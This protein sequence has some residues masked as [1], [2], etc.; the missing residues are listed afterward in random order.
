[1]TLDFARRPLS[2]YPKNLRAFYLDSL[3]AAMSL[4]AGTRARPVH[5]GLILLAAG[6]MR[7]V[8]AGPQRRLD[9]CR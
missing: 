4:W 8:Q 3:S 2:R 1:M 6:G 9:G 5:P 7:R